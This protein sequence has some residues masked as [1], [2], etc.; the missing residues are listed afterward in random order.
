MQVKRLH[1]YKRQFMNALSILAIY[2]GL[3]DGALTME[4]FIDRSLVEAFF[5][6]DKSVCV[7]AYGKAASQGLSLF[8]EGEVAIE[9]LEVF[10]VKSIYAE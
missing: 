8:A 7:R 10:S 1:E 9:G 5:N 2:Y 6:D 3:K 4:V